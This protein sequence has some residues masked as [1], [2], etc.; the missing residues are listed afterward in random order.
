M[1]FEIRSN[2]YIPRNAK[3]TPSGFPMCSTY[4]YLVNE[5]GKVVDKHTFKPYRGK[6]MD[7]Y[8]FKDK[9]YLE[10]LLKEINK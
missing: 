5:Q 6:N 3:S 7:R 4:Y 9:D 1:K 8:S 10:N 2:Q